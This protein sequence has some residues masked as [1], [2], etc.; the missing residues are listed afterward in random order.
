[1]SSVKARI[2]RKI[3]EHWL[4]E[5]FLKLCLE[6]KKGGL[7]E[8]TVAS[9]RLAWASFGLKAGIRGGQK[10]WSYPHEFLLDELDI[11][12]ITNKYVYSYMILILLSTSFREAV[13]FTDNGSIK[14]LD[15][16]GPPCKPQLFRVRTGWQNSV[17]FP[18]TNYN[19]S[20]GNLNIARLDD[21]SD[22]D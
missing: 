21:S 10:T 6:R 7:R 1:M 3:P 20:D 5:R 18:G 14:S 22:S 4:S 11:A 9:H 16:T 15:V 8:G 13:V 17:L 12:V 19:S 2:S